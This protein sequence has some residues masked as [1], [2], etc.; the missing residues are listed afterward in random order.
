MNE[1]KYTQWTQLTQKRWKR[2]LRPLR[3]CCFN[4]IFLFRHTDSSN[5]RTQN[6][7]GSEI[8]RKLACFSPPIFFGD[9]SPNFWTGVIK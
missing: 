4:Y 6:G 8:G 9:S 5:I 7:K 3:V 1:E 2:S